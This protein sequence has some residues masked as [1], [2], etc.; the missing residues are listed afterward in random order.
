MRYRL[1][2]REESQSVWR[3]IL[4][5][6]E[7]LTATEY[8]WNTSA[9]PDGYYVVAVEASDE[10]SNPDGLTL[11]SSSESEPMLVDNHPPSV[12]ALTFGGGRVRGTATDAMGPVARLEAAIDGG[13]WRVIFPDDDL[14]D[15]RE[16]SFAIDVSALAPG[17]HIVAVRAIDGGGNQAASEITVT[18]AG[19]VARAR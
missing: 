14:L 5:D 15:T 12:S 3:E 2:Y 11:R 8:Q 17:S 16:E 10:L 1:R 13:E 18:V 6:S 19:A 9:V 7:T 4:R